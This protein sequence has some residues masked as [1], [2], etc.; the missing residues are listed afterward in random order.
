MIPYYGTHGKSQR[1][2]NK[3]I[4]MGYD[5][6][7]LAEPYDDSLV[8]TTARCVKQAASLVKEN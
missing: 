1:I 3:S 2:K 4:R 6:W 5:I 7:V 8:R